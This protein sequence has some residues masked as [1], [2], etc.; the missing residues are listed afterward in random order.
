MIHRFCISHEKPLLPE[1]WYDDCISLGNFQPDSPLHVRHLDQFWH[2]A[3]PLAYGAAGTHV[4]PI[5]IERVSSRA[6]LI[7]ISLYRKRLLPSPVGIESLVYPTMREFNVCDVDDR[8]DLSVFE[9]SNGLEFLVAQPLYSEISMIGQYA[10]SHYRRDILDYTSLAIKMGVLD[11]AS[12]SDFLETKHII[13][14]GTEFGIFP[15]WWLTATLS[16]IERVAREFLHR[17]G[18]RLKTYGGYQIRTLGFLSERLGSYLLLR[19]LKDKYS[20]NIPADIFG[21]MTVIVE[22]DSNYSHGLTDRPGNASEEESRKEKW[23]S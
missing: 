16:D 7:E 14:G 13:P 10:I 20:N 3:R 8:A 11:S 23:T 17:Y 22:G 6:E 1:S 4:L 21:Y 9:P 12:A 15:K 19:H 18:Y 5:A 2:D